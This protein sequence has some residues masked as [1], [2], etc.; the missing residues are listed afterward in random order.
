[1]ED[2]LIPAIE[3]GNIAHAFLDVFE[4][5]PLAKSSP[6]WLH[7]KI[8][9]TPHIAAVS[10]PHQVF[11]QFK[12]NYLRWYDGFKLQNLVDFKKGY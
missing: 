9:V 8:T 10:F 7:D 3:N 2:D 5:E 12:E 11:D 1:M 6:F 4:Q